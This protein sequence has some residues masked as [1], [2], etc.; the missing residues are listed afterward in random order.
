MELEIKNGIGCGG[1]VSSVATMGTN[2]MHGKRPKNTGVEKGD[3]V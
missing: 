2:S 3:N 1:M